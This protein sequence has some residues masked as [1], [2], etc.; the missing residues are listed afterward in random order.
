MQEFKNFVLLATKGECPIQY[1]L[2]VMKKDSE[3]VVFL[4]FKTAQ[5]SPNSRVKSNKNFL[6]HDPK[7]LRSKLHVC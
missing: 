1:A 2:A 3:K 7:K 4:D 5:V 6:K